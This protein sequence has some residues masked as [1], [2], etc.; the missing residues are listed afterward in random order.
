MDKKKKELR[1]GNILLCSEFTPEIFSALWTWFPDIG[2][3]F[4]LESAEPVSVKMFLNDK[5]GHL[6]YN[7][8]VNKKD[9]TGIVLKWQER[10]RKKCGDYYPVA[11]ELPD[12]SNKS[13]ALLVECWICHG[14]KEEKKNK[15]LYS[16]MMERAEERLS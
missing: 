6:I 5:K 13:G 3:K 7:S 2:K 16:E 4:V 14:T 15:Q 9:L 12:I 11:K 10:M 8:D 1:P